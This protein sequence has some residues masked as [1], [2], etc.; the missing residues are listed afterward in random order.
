MANNRLDLR[1][2]VCQE[3]T[4]LA[5]YYPTLTNGWYVRGDPPEWFAGYLA[6]LEKHSFCDT[7]GNPSQWGNR[8]LSLVFEIPPE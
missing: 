6:F 1:C 7:G 3:T 5:N 2:D 8:R 4:R